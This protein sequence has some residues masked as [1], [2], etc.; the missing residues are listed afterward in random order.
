MAYEL[1]IEMKGGIL[2]ENWLELCESD[3]T[4]THKKSINITNPN[5]NEVIFIQ[6]EGICILVD[7]GPLATFDFR[8]G[9]ISFR[10]SDDALIKAKEIALKLN[11]I[12]IGDEGET[13]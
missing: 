5:T 4:L 12:I 13:Y 10:Y 2:L 11:A 9:K 1:H 6:A 3:S 8:S 7:E